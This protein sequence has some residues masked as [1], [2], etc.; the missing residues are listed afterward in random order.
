M[1]GVDVVLDVIGGDYLRN[2]AALAMGGR[3]IQVGVMA[4]KPVPF[5]VSLLMKRASVR[6]RRF[7]PVRS[8]RRSPSPENCAQPP[9][10]CCRHAAS[11]DRFRYSIED[12]AAAH[13]RMGQNANAGKLV[14]DVMAP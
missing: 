13:I 14:I 3:I 9:A 8:K 5:D 11:H 2:I 10:C 6:E 12:I 7:D 1:V 4:A